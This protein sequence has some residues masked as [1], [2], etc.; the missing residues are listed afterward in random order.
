MAISLPTDDQ[1]PGSPVN[2]TELKPR[3]FARP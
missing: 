2:V 1:L 3:Y